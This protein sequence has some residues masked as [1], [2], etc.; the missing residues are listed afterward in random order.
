MR[1][2]FHWQIDYTDT[3]DGV[4]GYRYLLVAVDA[5]TSWPEAVHT[6]K[7]DA[8][9]VIK[10][11]I[12]QYIPQHEFPAKIRSDNETHFKKPRSSTG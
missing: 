9:S 11:L 1:A 4:H 5:Y 8:K 10:F 3:I 6:K 7:E 2:D 12:N